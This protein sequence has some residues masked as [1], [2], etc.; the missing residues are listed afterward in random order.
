MRPMR[1]VAGLSAVALVGCVAVGIGIAGGRA[2]NAV[3][4]TFFDALPD[5]PF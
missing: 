5:R 3:R 1:L 4:L 2:L